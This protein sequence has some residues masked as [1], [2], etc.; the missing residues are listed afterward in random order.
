MHGGRI[1][2]L[3]IDE[4]KSPVI[5]EYK[6]A[7]NENVMNQGLFYLDWLLDHKAEFVLLVQRKIGVAESENIDWL[8]ARLLCISG[9][10]TRYDEHAVKQI[11]R[12]IELIRYRR[13]GDNLLLLELV[14]A[15]TGNAEAAVTTEPRTR[16]TEA[17]ITE[18]LARSSTTVKDRYE[19]IKAFLLALGD[20]VQ[21]MTLKFYF[22]FKRIKNFACVEIH[23]Q[24]NKIVVF[25]KADMDTITY[26][27]GFSRDT[28]HIGHYGTGDLELT[29]DSDEDIEK[30]KTY[31]I[32]SYEEN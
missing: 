28:R 15:T 3:G 7:L 10:F 4:N 17:T 13:Y 29:I 8:G 24:T 25:V 26:E 9:D 18:K 30:A 22:A 23:P 5:I 32:C 2:T 21:E 19:S 1:D 11:N 12:N 31:I 6:R 14:N 20:D 16:Y 27:D